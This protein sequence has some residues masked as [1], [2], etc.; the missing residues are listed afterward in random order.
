MSVD[1]SILRFVLALTIVG[2]QITGGTAEGHAA[3]DSGGRCASPRSS[4]IVANSAARV[5]SKR[6]RTGGE[7]RFYLCSRTTGKKMFLGP[8]AR[9]LDVE[10]LSVFRLR[11]ST[12]AYA[13]QYTRFRGG[14]SYQVYV[15]S[16]RTGKVIRVVEAFDNQVPDRE[17]A[18]RDPVGLTDLVVTEHGALA[19]IA[20]NPFAAGSTREVRKSDAAGDAL[21]DSG[22]AIDLRSL[23]PRGTGVAWREGRVRRTYAFR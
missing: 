8:R 21:L 13:R 11:G 18:L 17:R 14:S 3:R 15:R 1:K 6:T 16:A 12:L 10:S 4:T 20:R 23:T 19:W 9:D 5:F 22:S 7:R 2:F